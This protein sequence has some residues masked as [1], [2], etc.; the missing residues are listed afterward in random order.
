MSEL[1]VG[2]DPGQTNQGVVIIDKDLK[3]VARTDT[4]NK[5]PKDRKGKNLPDI[6][7]N[8]YVYYKTKELIESVG[9]ENIK[10]CVMEGPNYSSKF[11]VTPIS[12]GSIHGQNQM[13][14]WDQQIDFIVMPPRSIQVAIHGSSV[15]VTKQT[16]KLKMQEIFGIEQVPK[17]GFSYN[18][19]DALSMAYLARQ[20]YLLMTG[21]VSL[22]VG[23]QK[24][25]LASSKTKN[26][27]RGLVYNFGKRLF[28][29]D[30]NGDFGKPE[31]GETLKDFY[32]R[33]KE[34]K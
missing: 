6:V 28:I 7:R 14:F 26:G 12:I 33:I 13:Y 10:L 2:L 4:G 29:F 19:S 23:E 11:N 17:K 15:D 27:K 1:F 22:T 20:F 5:I 16:T 24:V 25:F 3:I 8:S 9:I 34:G 32:S 18:E 30:K 21:E 31:S